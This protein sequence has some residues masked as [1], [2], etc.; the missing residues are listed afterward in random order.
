MY[1][2]QDPF[3]QMECSLLKAPTMVQS[4]G[5]TSEGQVQVQAPTKFLQDI[6]ETDVG[7]PLLKVVVFLHSTRKRK[8]NL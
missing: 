4:Y 6:W 5:N 1:T 7:E 3:S 2:K 8:S